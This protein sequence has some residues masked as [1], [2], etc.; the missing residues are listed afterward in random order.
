MRSR[1]PDRNKYT[2]RIS[3]YGEFVRRRSE[4]VLQVEYSESRIVRRIVSFRRILR[5]SYICLRS[6]IFTFSRQKDNRPSILVDNTRGNGSTKRF[7]F[8]F[9]FS[10]SFPWI[11]RNTLRFEVSHFKEFFPSRLSPDISQ[12]LSLMYCE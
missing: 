9:F 4:E 3:R 1:S 10:F 12:L 7:S 5:H 11:S 6:E 2:N 8:F